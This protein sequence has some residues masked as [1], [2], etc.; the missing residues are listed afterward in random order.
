MPERTR[1][2]NG[3]DI[4]LLWLKF[5]AK[6]KREETTNAIAALVSILDIATPPISW[7]FRRDSLKTAVSA[8]YAHIK[9]V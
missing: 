2:L 6:K 4:L 5:A 7:S 9:K 1:S 3:V 8:P